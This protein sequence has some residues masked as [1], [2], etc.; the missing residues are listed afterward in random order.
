LTLLWIGSLWLFSIDTVVIGPLWLFSIE[1][2]V[3]G[4]LWGDGLYSKAQISHPYKIGGSHNETVKLEYLIVDNILMLIFPEHILNNPPVL[5]TLKQN[6][7]R[8][9]YKLHIA[10]LIMFLKP[11]LYFQELFH[12]AVPIHFYYNQ[13]LTSIKLVLETVHCCV[14]LCWR[15]V[16]ASY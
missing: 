3:I 5:S 10:P 6:P 7:F 9:S 1:P 14:L 12:I 2:V 8:N 15:L 4:S 16:Y 11:V 13:L